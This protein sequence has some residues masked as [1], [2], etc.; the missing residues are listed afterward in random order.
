MS[1]PPAVA[2]VEAT[3]VGGQAVPAAPPQFGHQPGTY[4]TSHHRRFQHYFD[5]AM[6]ASGLVAGIV[7][8]GWQYIPW[9]NLKASLPPRD[10]YS[11]VQQSS[12]FK[13]VSMGV[14]IEHFNPLVEKIVSRTG[15]VAIENVFDSHPYMM[16]LIDDHLVLDPL[17]L[18]P[19]G[20]TSSFYN[21]NTQMT[22]CW[23]T[24]QANGA[25]IRC[26]FDLGDEF[27]AAV[28]K[29][30]ETVTA[31]GSFNT[32]DGFNVDTVA[33]G[34][35]FSRTWTNG[36][37]GSRWYTTTG[38]KGQPEG[39]GINVYKLS[40]EI[41]A[42]ESNVFTQVN[43]NFPHKPPA[44]LIKIN[45]V[46]GSEGAIN[47]TGQIFVTYTC[48]IQWERRPQGLLFLGIP[49]SRTS[50]DAWNHVQGPIYGLQNARQLY[51][52]QAASSYQVK[53]GYEPAEPSTS[54]ATHKKSQLGS[55]ATPY[56]QQVAATRAQ[57]L[58]EASEDF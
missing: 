5:N 8:E 49:A 9:R 42:L 19:T 14:Q 58:E 34:G 18:K 6:D 1:D 2:P 56:P 44:I 55:R 15:T 38:Y 23:P 46:F 28:T 53:D 17:L 41:G 16:V 39:D 29:S 47:I 7:D 24:S 37:V 13:I 25:L 36:G 57:L 51:K 10:F 12:A 45:P 11:N 35:G 52:W 32:L 54:G 21:P 4:T 33:A 27:R 43:A 31:W 48:T 30:K 26:K 3:T 50:G 22:A 40:E 20:P